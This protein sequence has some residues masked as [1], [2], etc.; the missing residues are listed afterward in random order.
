MIFLPWN[1]I[2]LILI[3]PLLL[4]I[5]VYMVYVFHHFTFTLSI[6]LHW[7]WISYRQHLVGSCFQSILHSLFFSSYIYMPF[8]FNVIIYLLG[9]KFTLLFSM[10]LCSNFCFIPVGY[11]NFIFFL[12]L[13]FWFICS[14]WSVFLCIASFSAC[15]TYTYTKPQFTGIILLKVFVK[16]RNLI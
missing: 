7:K 5:D 14:V 2:Y 6:S 1:L 3:K 11:M 10:L 15:S 13:V 9:H 12:D 4:F 8:I 16:C